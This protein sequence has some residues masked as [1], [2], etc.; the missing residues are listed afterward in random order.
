MSLKQALHDR[1]WGAF[2]RWLDL[3]AATGVEKKELKMRGVRE[4]GDR[5]HYLRPLIVTG[6]TM[7][8]YES[9]L[10]RFIAA[11]PEARRLEDL[12]KR[13]FRAFIEA[14]IARGLSASSLRTQCSALSKLGALTG[15]SASFSGLARRYSARI[16]E[17]VAAG[18]LH[19]P[20]RKT[21]GVEL[22]GR[23]LEVLR[24]WDARHFARTGVPRGYHLSRCLQWET[25][26]RA[27]SAT[28]RMTADCLLPGNRVTIIGKGGR[29]DVFEISPE[30]HAR[31]RAWFTHYR[32]PLAD[33]RGYQSAYRRAIKAAGG[34]ATGT[35]GAR[36]AAVQSF[37]R[38]VYSEHRASGL[39]PAG[40]ADR[41]AGDAIERL[42]HS[43]DRRDHRSCYLGK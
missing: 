20:S 37:F 28:E 7:R 5:D 41:A 3:R 21:P 13:E 43:R 6:N 8:T 14:G 29:Q 10:R 34:R 36:R 31:L 39:T 22:L 12:G 16:R 32:G 24:A 1:L 25:C 4:F 33:L 42:G 11:F 26:C 27:V 35:H 40:A 15:Q 23:Q 30:L 38:L 19:G 17:L 9:I 18:H 2:Q